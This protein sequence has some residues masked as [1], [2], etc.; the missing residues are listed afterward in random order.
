M[1]F[2]QSLDAAAKNL[3][4]QIPG[5]GKTTYTKFFLSGVLIMDKLLTGILKDK[6][7][8][9]WI[10]ANSDGIRGSG[11]RVKRCFPVIQSWEGEIPVHILNDV[12]D[13]AIFERVLR[14]A[15]QFIGVGRFRPE[16]G[17]FYGRFEVV[18]TRWEDVTA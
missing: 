3:G 14:E 2:K 8:G 7:E 1:A 10:N 17:G 6:V 4:L 12:I 11:K 9:E 15:G 18:K 5:K 13:T 16:K